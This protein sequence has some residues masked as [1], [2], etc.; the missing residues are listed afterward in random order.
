VVE[1]AAELACVSGL[2][3][4]RR[5]RGSQRADACPT[6]NQSAGGRPVQSGP[7]WPA[8]RAAARQC[9]GEQKSGPVRP[10]RAGSQADACD[11]MRACMRAYWR[12]GWRA[13]GRACLLSA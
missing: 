1:C 3:A 2:I 13:S 11:A 10:A 7:G 4:R 12:A 8:V 9:R 6:S 5:G